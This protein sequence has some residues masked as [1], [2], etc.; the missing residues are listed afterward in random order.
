MLYQYH[1]YM[2]HFFKISFQTSTYRDRDCHHLQKQFNCILYPYPITHPSVMLS[3]K[4]HKHLTAST[5]YRFNYF[6]NLHLYQWTNWKVSKYGTEDII[7]IQQHVFHFWILVKNWLSKGIYTSIWIG[8]FSVTHASKE[9]RELGRGKEERREEGRDQ[10]RQ[11]GKEKRNKKEGMVWRGHY[12]TKEVT[13]D[14]WTSFR[15][16]TFSKVVVEDTKMVHESFHLLLFS[17]ILKTYKTPGLGLSKKVPERE[18][19]DPLK[20][21]ALQGALYCSPWIH[22]ILVRSGLFP[23]T[24]S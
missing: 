3:S 24:Y 8:D 21:C 19:Y 10:K 15:K 23:H 12:F 7:H 18:R 2:T 16:Q 4:L 14:N 20:G 22:S 13:N 9:R 1:L 17:L 6:P 5:T 11:R